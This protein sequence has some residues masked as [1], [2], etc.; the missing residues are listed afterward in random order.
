VTAASGSPEAAVRDLRTQT[1]QSKVER[2]SLMHQRLMA[3][4]LWRKIAV[5]LPI[6]AATVACVPAAAS[7]ASVAPVIYTPT[8]TT[9]LQTDISQADG[10]TPGTLSIIQLC[11]C[12]YQPTE[13]LPLS[14]DIE[15]TGPPTN[16]AAQGTD[17]NI[18]GQTVFNLSP[19]VP[20]FVVNSGASVLFKAVD[21]ESAGNGD[22]VGAIQDS[23][24]VEID[25]SGI[26]GSLGSALVVNSGATAYL[27]NSDISG[28]TAD[29]VENSGTA[30][31]TNDTLAYNAYGALAGSGMSIYNSYIYKDHEENTAG[32]SCVNTTGD[33]F[34][35]D[36]AD[37]ST[38]GTT[39]V[40]VASTLSRYTGQVGYNGGPDETVNLKTGNPAIGKGLAAYCPPSDGRFF[41]YT[42]GSGGTCDVGD[43]QTTG[44]EDTGTTGPT[45]TVGTT[46]ESSNVNVPSTMTV[47]VTDPAG[48]VGIGPDVVTTTTTNNGTVMLPT[49]SG[50]WF[51]TELTD[52]PYTVTAQKPA[53]DLTVGDTSWSFYASDWLGN[54]T[55]CD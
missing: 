16:Q 43:Y 28:G 42:Q 11:G 36:Y 13:S 33:T 52:G 4:R 6:A 21:I 23:G 47:N 15:I 45:C 25:N 9:A 22:G 34:A 37:D 17:A 14:G 49:V 2:Q 31:L 53:G 39:G 24:S 38:C 55:Y 51:D 10:A 32:G 50:S 54:S 46:T 20:L 1:I 12:S 3:S 48:G 30:T 27:T 19:A 40:T 35:G 29:G 26:I 41:L 44:T 7:A 5:A 18:N 8:T